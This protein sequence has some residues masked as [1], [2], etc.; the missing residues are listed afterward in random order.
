MILIQKVEEGKKKASVCMIFDMTAA[1]IGSSLYSDWSWNVCQ[2]LF[3]YNN[4][5][6]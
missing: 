2:P 4:D 6:P 3:D 5:R 1:V